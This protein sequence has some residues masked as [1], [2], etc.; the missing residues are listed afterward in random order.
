MFLSYNGKI[1]PSS[2]PILLADNRGFRYADGVFETM[3]MYNGEIR[4]LKMHFDRLFT[5]M[6]KLGI[7]LPKLYNQ[8]FIE[9][10]IRHL[11]EKNNCLNSARIRV[12]ISNGNGGIFEK[13][14]KGNLLIECWTLPVSIADLNEN[15]L[16]VGIYGDARKTAD[17]ISSLKTLNAIQ[18]S[19]AARYAEEQHLN[20]VLLLNSNGSIA[21]S[22][23]ANLFIIKEGVVSTPSLDQACVSGVM[24]RYLIE[25]LPAMGY[26]V[27]EKEIT[28]QELLD[29]DE[30]FLTNAVREI[31]W[32]KE[33]NGKYFTNAIIVKIRK[34]LFN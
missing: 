26:Q 25:N 19:L 34:E 33:I 27:I 13:D 1:Q 3:R 17:S 4:L 7:R 2:E 24:R 9:Q 21:D 22:T 15:G 12:T 18:Y 29:A 10:Q 8:Q 30:V 16:V 6:E 28:I 5:S 32:V 14:Q 11:V 23:I 20:D 31:K